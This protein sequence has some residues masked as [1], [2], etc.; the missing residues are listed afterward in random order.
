MVISLAN[1]KGKL[2]LVFHFSNLEKRQV[3]NGVVMQSFYCMITNFFDTTGI[4]KKIT[5]NDSN[6]AFE[7]CCY[8]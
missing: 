6:F 2:G 8:W 5:E 4:I 3:K 1:V 7:F